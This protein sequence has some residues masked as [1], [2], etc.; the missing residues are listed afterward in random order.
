MGRVTAEGYEIHF[1][2]NALGHYYLTKLLIPLLRASIKASP[3]NPPRVCFTSSYGHN[4]AAKGFDPAD[5]AGVEGRG[6][7]LMGSTSAYAHSKMGNVLTALKFQREYGKEGIVFTAVN[8]G[9]LKTNIS[10]S[11]SGILRVLVNYIITPVLLYPQEYGAITQLYANTAP[12]TQG[13]GGAYFVPWARRGEPRAIAKD[14]AVQDKCTWED[15][16]SELTCSCRVV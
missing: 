5:P 2:T 4:A 13:D 14:T 9:N 7:G 6:K 3:T 8:P 16:T 1:G 12:E 15:V 10:R 11:A